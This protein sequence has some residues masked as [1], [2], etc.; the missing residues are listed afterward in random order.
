MA[1]MI[2]NPKAEGK[3]NNEADINF[4]DFTLLG[5]QIGRAADNI[6]AN[7]YFLFFNESK[8]V[9]IIRHSYLL[10]KETIDDEMAY[11][12][13]PIH[14]ILNMKKF[15]GAV[16][17]KVDKIFEEFS[18]TNS[19]YS[20]FKPVS[21][22]DNDVSIEIVNITVDKIT[23]IRKAHIS[24]GDYLK[25]Q[26]ISNSI[27]FHRPINSSLE[28]DVSYKNCEILEDMEVN[29]IGG[30]SVNV[31]RCEFFAFFSITH[32]NSIKRIG[33]AV[34]VVT[35]KENILVADTKLDVATFGT[36]YKENYMVDAS[37]LLVLPI[38]VNDNI[39]YRVAINIL[40]SKSTRK[41]IITNET[42]TNS[43]LFNP[44]KLMFLE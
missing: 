30:Q 19:Y 5:F 27:M 40:R 12:N 37:K 14:T 39:E 6:T 20:D 22:K 15:T 11:F 31:E 36:M 42:I 4:V 32:P 25:L 26:T 24:M 8:D 1:M 3:V 13:H 10:N 38:I 28:R 9:F 34:P 43:K 44:I 29:Y 23:H 21:M 33:V 16:K 17:D 41:I 35:T 7:L 18:H 2:V